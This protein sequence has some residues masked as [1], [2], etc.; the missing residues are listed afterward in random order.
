[1]KQS[2]KGATM[3]W[4]QFLILQKLLAMQPVEEAGDMDRLTIAIDNTRDM[5]VR[6]T[7]TLERS[8][9]G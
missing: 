1:M 4:D 2:L 7:E 3:D 6:L 5:L 8:T 9:N